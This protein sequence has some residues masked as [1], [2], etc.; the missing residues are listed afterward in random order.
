VAA[1]PHKLFLAKKVGRRTEI[2]PVKVDLIAHSLK[3][4]KIMIVSTSWKY[5]FLVSGY[6]ISK[7]V[8][9]LCTFMHG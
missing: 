7:K 8:D 6:K 4:L 9:F 5:V 3:K 1:L 2:K